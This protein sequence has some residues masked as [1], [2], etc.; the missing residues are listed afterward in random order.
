MPNLELTMSRKQQFLAEPLIQQS[1][2]IKIANGY[3]YS[4]A[5]EMEQ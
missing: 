5:A 1:Q 4:G 3:Y 2:Q